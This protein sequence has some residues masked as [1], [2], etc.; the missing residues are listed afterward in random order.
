MKK[1]PLNLLVHLHPLLPLTMERRIVVIAHNIRSL[2]NIGSLFRSADAFQVEHIHL[3]GY[4]PTPPRKEI[5]K[6]ALGADEWIPWS[7]H[8]SAIA[9]LDQRRQQGFL[10]A[11]LE[12]T[13][14]STPLMSFD[15]PDKICLII[16][17]EILGVPNE[18][19]KL[20]DSV[21]SIPMAG[22]KASLNV[23]VASG[24]ALYQLRCS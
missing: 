17:H 7:K 16:G 9:V 2:W 19:L 21:L 4:T 8:D 14:D 12:L 11:A 10:V 1:N 18:I 22:K 15:A 3:C 13:P 23:S 6:T 5:A 24:I 20:C